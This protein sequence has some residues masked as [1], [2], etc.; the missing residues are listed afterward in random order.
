MIIPGRFMSK[1]N[2]YL[3]IGKDPFTDKR[4]SIL[5]YYL[6][7]DINHVGLIDSKEHTLRGNHY[8]P[9]QTQV[10][11]LVKGSYISVTKN[12]QEK[13]SVVESRLIRENE[14]SIIPPNVAHAM[15]FLEDSIFLNL[16]KGERSH[17]NFDKTH[18]LKYE[19][20]KKDQFR[21]YIDFFKSTCRVCESKFLDLVHSFGQVPL[22]NNLLN[23]KN[24]Y[25]KEYPLELFFCCDCSNL[26]LNMAI[27][28]DILFRDYLYTSSTSSLFVQHFEKFAEQIIQEEDLNE[29]SLVVDIGSN[30]GVFLEPLS[31]RGIKAIGVEPAKNL[32]EYS[33]NKGLKTINSYFNEQAVKHIF[34]D[35]GK[36]DLVTAFNV[37]AHGDGL[38]EIVLHVFNL[39]KDDGVFLLEVQS[40]EKMINNNL[41][42]NIYHE[43]FNYW[44]LGTLIT[45]FNNLNLTVYKFEEVA[46]HGGSLRLYVAKNRK[47]DKSVKTYLLEESKSNLNKK[48]TF[49]NFSAN[50]EKEKKNVLLNLQNLINSDKN[51][52]FYG[53]PAKATTLLNYFKIDSQLVKYTIEDNS[54]KVGKF[55]PNT[56]IEVI[57]KDQAISY[58]PEI[59]IVL[60]WNFFES[61][62]NNNQSTFP[63]AQFTTLKDLQF[64]KGQ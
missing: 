49:L 28:P 25:A 13:N 59:I 53:A 26:Q 55:I 33:N 19:L 54:L 31:I 27:D 35:H 60:A 20:V 61:I 63:N 3:E 38:K 52:I 62:K 39:L 56:G 46:T 22:A 24:E 10:C 36:A 41:F 16:V 2:E 29:E 43:H 57:N 40:T 21:T 23:S 7:E 42:D 8:H 48:E 1:K 5:N 11:L 9:E 6:P 58:N 12:I 51:I 30:D 18:T 45:F 34:Q 64:I 4:G 17:E 14:L 37:F 47:V 32:S 44:S 50:I 15:I